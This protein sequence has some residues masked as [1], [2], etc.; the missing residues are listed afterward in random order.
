MGTQG[1]LNGCHNDVMNVK[2]FLVSRFGFRDNPNDM[3]VLMDDEYTMRNRPAFVPTRANIINAMNWLVSG[4]QPG[5]SLFFHFSGHGGRVRDTS[6]D[7]TDGY[8]ETILPLDYQQAGQILDDEMHSVMVGRLMPGV[9]LTAI[10]DS[11]HSGTALDLPYLYDPNGRLVLEEERQQQKAQS[12]LQIG[13]GL[14][15]VMG[16]MP[17]SGLNMIKRNGG[18]LFGSGNGGGVSSSA[19]IQ[20]RHTFSD[21]IMFSSCK[22]SQTAADARIQGFGATGAMSYAFLTALNVSHPLTYT[23]LLASMRTILA[24]KYF[25]QIPQLSSG[26]PMDMNIYFLM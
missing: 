15:M 2:S 26:H 11:C 22:D 6:G 12:A 25:G 23:Q 7:E 5:D 8:D 4:N 24:Q 10:F 16:G 9:R 3:V 20:Q 1:Q 19:A 17:I 14:A 21:V 13:L 18:S